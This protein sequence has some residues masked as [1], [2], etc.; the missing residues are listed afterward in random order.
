MPRAEVDQLA[1]KLLRPDSGSVGEQGEGGVRLAR[2][3]GRGRRGRITFGHG[4]STSEL[5]LQCSR[6][7]RC[8]GS[9]TFHRIAGVVAGVQVGSLE[10]AKIDVRRRESNTWWV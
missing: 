3:D 4:N 10:G 7:I 8:N 5:V 2:L 6:P 1:P 9:A